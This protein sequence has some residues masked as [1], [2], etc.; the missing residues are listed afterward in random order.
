MPTPS[1]NET[2][3]SSRA[4]I[5]PSAQLVSTLAA[6]VGPLAMGTGVIAP[7]RALPFSPEALKHLE[8]SWRFDAS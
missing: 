7:K 8:Q 2:L 6:R 1:Q 5:G 3:A 4:I